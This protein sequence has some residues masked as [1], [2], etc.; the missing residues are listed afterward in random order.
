MP[1]PLFS[2]GFPI[3]ILYVTSEA[4]TSVTVN[5]AVFWNMTLCSFIDAG[6][7]VLTAVVTTSTIFW[8]MTPFSPLRVNRCYIPEDGT[9]PFHRCLP[10]VRIHGIA[11]QKKIIF[12]MLCAF[13]IAS[14]CTTRLVCH[15]FRDLITQIRFGERSTSLHVHFLGRETQ[16]S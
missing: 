14:M 8:D 6:F 9:L 1:R 16:V 13:I 12:K 4:L 3:H 2:S 7:E 11:F 5:I 15:V 10:S